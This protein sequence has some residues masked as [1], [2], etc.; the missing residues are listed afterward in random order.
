M[1]AD[2]A[3]MPCYALSGTGGFL[4]ERGMREVRETLETNHG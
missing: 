3:A 1:M 2:A 4:S